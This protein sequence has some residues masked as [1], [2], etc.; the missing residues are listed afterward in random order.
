VIEHSR[1]D[2]NF[3]IFCRFFVLCNL[4]QIRTELPKALL[5]EIPD[6]PS[7]T[8]LRMKVGDLGRIKARNQPDDGI[9]SKLRH[10]WL[11]DIRIMCQE[12]Y[13][14]PAN[15]PFTFN[16]TKD[17]RSLVI[18]NHIKL[19]ILPNFAAAVEGFSF[20]IGE[21]MHTT[22]K[23]RCLGNPALSLITVPPLS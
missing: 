10:E 3:D 15:L 8:S 14:S 13:R 20:S 16:S 17:L 23:Q 22:T 11:S 19:K 7:W 2:V 9:S 1:P 4:L 12:G 18:P 5:S 21:S 6:E